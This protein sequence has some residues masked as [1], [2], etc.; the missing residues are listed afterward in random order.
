MVCPSSIAR[1]V[2]SAVPDR[3]NVS[4]GEPPHLVLPGPAMPPHIV[5]EA[6]DSSWEMMCLDTRGSI[7][8][9][10]FFL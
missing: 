1:S 9:V 2:N 6:A 3:P 10:F 8:F 7:F 4:A 5:R